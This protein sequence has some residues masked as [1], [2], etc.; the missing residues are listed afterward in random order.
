MVP[1]QLFCQQCLFALVVLLTFAETAWVQT[2]TR[3]DE[4]LRTRIAAIRQKIDTAASWHATDDQLGMLWR[5]LANDYADELDFQQSENAFV[6]SLKLVQTS[7]TQQ[8]YAAVLADLASLYVATDRLKEGES[9][10]N[11][12]LAIYEGLGE[13]VGTTRVRVGLAIAFLHDHRFAE[14][15][16]ASAKAL[17]SLQEQK[18]PNQS[19]LVTALISNSY[20]KCF[21]GRCNEGLV[22]AGQA[23][24]IA[25]AAFS[26]DSLELVTA[27]LALGF[28]QWKTGAAADGEKAM[29]EALEILR[30]KKNMPYPRL[31]DAQLKVL[32]S[33][34]NYLKATHQKVEAKQVENE[35]TRLKQQQ[36]PYCTDCTVNVMTLSK[37]MR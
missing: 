26:K 12:A 16:D 34:S 29:R 6:H 18:E 4:V 2:V 14:S 32:T 3:A 21:L 30:Q 28:E 27:L 31:V 1:R 10:G 13:Q 22:A 5:Q 33:Y 8:L 19:D 37:A 35:I 17:K 24:G 15:E 7:P 20:A 23:V 11:K 36:M 25:S 9:C